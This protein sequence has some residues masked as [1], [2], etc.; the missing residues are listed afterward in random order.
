MHINKHSQYNSNLNNSNAK[1]NN[2]ENSGREFTLDQNQEHLNTAGTKAAQGFSLKGAID[3]TYKYDLISINGATPEIMRPR[4]SQQALDYH[5]SKQRIEDTRS[6]YEES[7]SQ[8][9]TEALV[10]VNGEVVAMLG[11]SGA[12]ARNTYSRYIEQAGG[13]LDK[14]AE[15]LGQK[16]SDVSIETFKPGEGPTNAEAFELFN[17]LPFNDFI[18][19]EYQVSLDSYNKNQRH[20]EENERQRVLYQ[21]TPQTAVFSVGDTVV[22]SINEKG[23][24]DINRNIL[25]LADEQGVDREQLKS[26]YSYDEYS[27]THTEKV[28]SML[29]SIF[30]EVDVSKYQGENMPTLAEVKIQ[31]K[32]SPLST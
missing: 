28:T 3:L 20:L 27:N 6:H 13:D 5:N 22:G 16:F 18:E 30:G 17:G 32:T 8:K 23:F 7:A 15:L 14:L 10:R 31:A 25:K 19:R 2:K 29:K 4:L 26:F 12:A 9:E 21:Q 1:S 24:L 11:G